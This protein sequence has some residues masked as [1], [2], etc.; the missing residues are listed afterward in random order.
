MT[1]KNLAREA[2]PTEGTSAKRNGERRSDNGQPVGIWE[3]LAALGRTVPP[4][5]LERLPTDLSRNLDHYLY[6][7]PKRA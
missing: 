3:V 5:E 7:V 6:G 2:T 4:D 1:I